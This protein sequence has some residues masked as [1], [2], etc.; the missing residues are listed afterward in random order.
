M[1]RR[2][3]ED[4]RSKK[5]IYLLLAKVAKLSKLSVAIS[6]VKDIIFVD[7]NNNFTRHRLYALDRAGSTA[8]GWSRGVNPFGL[9]FA[10]RQW[11]ELLKQL[12]IRYWKTG[13][14]SIRYEYT[15]I[16]YHPFRIARVSD[17]KQRRRR[18]SDTLHIYIYY[19]CVGGARVH[20]HIRVKGLQQVPAVTPIIRSVPPK[21]SVISAF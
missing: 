2:W 19:T 7:L 9:S 13:K 18:P 11:N 14:R 3:L 10:T 21:T 20:A 6:I 1:V 4:G 8:D 12:T 5:N 15:C 17:Q 16:N